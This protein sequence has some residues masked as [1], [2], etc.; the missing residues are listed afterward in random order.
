VTVD[1]PETFSARARVTS[2]IVSCAFFM[3]QLDGSVIAT[4]LPQIGVSFGVHAVDVALGMTAYLVA[5]AAFIPVSGWVADRIGAKTT[6]CTAIVLFALASVACGFC[7]SLAAFVATRFAQGAAGAMMVPVGR[8]LVLRTASKQ[9]LI[10]A[11]SLITWPGLI[12]PVLGPP[13]GGFITTYASWRWIFFLN[14]PL[15]I[16]GLICA[17]IFIRISEHE[18]RR[19]FDAAGFVLSVATLVALMFG[20]DQL[21]RGGPVLHS[22]P[23]LLGGAVCA[24]LWRR[25]MRASSAPIL[26]FAPLAYGTFAA[27]VLRGSF[28]RVAIQTAP[29]ML[30]LLFQIGFGRSAFASGLLLLCYAAGNVAMKAIQTF[31]LRR[32]GFRG[33]ILGNGAL[34]ALSLIACGLI[35]AG[36][37]DIVTALVLF[38]AGLVRSLQYGAINTLGF[39]D[40][41]QP[42]MGAASTLSS[43]A[44]Q[45][46]SAGGIAFGALLLHGIVAL[47]HGGAVPD[48]SDFHIAFFASAALA[49][50]A[51]LSLWSL[52]SD[53]GA[54]VSGRGGNP[55]RMR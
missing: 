2:V 31:A 7:G 44:F 6:F 1:V 18:E 20:L 32:F 37:P 8:T 51:A 53:A 49:L 35:V 40:I 36:T 29:F 5:L 27:S 26:S 33:V 21:A 48:V 30:P 13:I 17:L 24:L 15:A 38:A 46:A 39:V 42:M 45:I 55:E 9:E 43:M 28:F 3:E 54:A 52:P 41:P 25:Q 19:P 22:A 4:S 14:V 16:A 34:V 23:L 12:A 10:R 11:V 50:A 47:R